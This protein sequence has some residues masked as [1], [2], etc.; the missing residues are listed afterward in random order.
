MNELKQTWRINTNVY[1]MIF[2]SA[3][4]DL[5]EA[6]LQMQYKTVQQYTFIQGRENLFTTLKG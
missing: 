5:M 3:E 2:Y 1:V 6:N 4:V